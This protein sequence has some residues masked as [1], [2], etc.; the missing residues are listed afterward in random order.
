MVFR[1]LV[2]VA[3]VFALVSGPVAG[4]AAQDRSSAWRALLERDPSI[5]DDASVDWRQRLILHL[6]TPGQAEA[7]FSGRAAAEELIL[8]DGRTLAAALEEPAPRA[9]GVY[10]PLPVSCR[11][12]AAVTDEPGAAG[13]HIERSFKL[14]RFDL[15]AQGGSSS[16]CPV[17]Q[18]AMA[19]VLQIRVQGLGLMQP[20]LKLWADGMPEPAAAAMERSAELAFEDRTATT[21]VNLCAGPEC[22]ASGLR[23]KSSHAAAVEADL[24]GYFRPLSAADGAGSRPI[25]P[26]ALESSS[27]NFFGTGAGANTTTA[28]RNSFFGAS[29]GA[30][31]TEGS[32]NAFFGFRAGFSNTTGELNAF[33]GRSAGSSNASGS[34]NAFFGHNAGFHNTAS[35]NSFFGQNAGFSNT[36]GFDNSFFGSSAGFSNTTG[37]SNSF[38][39]R[40]AGRDNTSGFSNNFFGRNAG[41]NNTTGSSNSFFGRGAGF[42]NTTGAVNSFFGRFT[43]NSNTTGV[44]NSF[45]GGDAGFNNTT[46]ASNSFF[47]RFAGNSNTV[48]DNNTFIGSFSRGAAGVANA[49]ALGHRAQVLQSNSLVL[50]SIAGLN[51]AFETPHASVNV[52]IGTP[53]PARQLHLAGSNAVFRMDR[54]QNTAAFILVRTNAS[55]DPLKTF[56]VGTNASGANNGEFIINDLGQAVGG[57]GARRLT[58]TNAGEAH[59]TGTVRAPAFQQT[60]SLRYKSEVETVARAIDLLSRLRGVRFVWKESGEPSLGLIAEEAADV[61]PEL[62]AINEQSG[63]AEAVNYAALTAVLIEA[64][65]EQQAEIQTLQAR[66]NRLETLEARFVQMESLL[67]GLLGA[68]EHRTQLVRTSEGR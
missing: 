47:G 8:S 56:V 3:F 7:Y 60:S 25:F 36:S 37:S 58:I 19:V 21:V 42:S 43:G 51:E 32:D 54:D 39:G 10:V 4:A 27:N 44:S 67:S 16:G 15:S 40:D 14:G 9:G 5:A 11:L 57:E 65:K 34:R 33:F 46:G 29:S 31:N 41:T 24:I 1:L 68:R 28:E 38:F 17:L 64:V 13:V 61:V 49:T 30:A 45:F 50:G 48:E 20:R 2:S 18:D 35:Q 63:Q 12:F 66:L 53:A 55:G 23:L 62:I 22:G 52:G 26:F 59:F 6:L